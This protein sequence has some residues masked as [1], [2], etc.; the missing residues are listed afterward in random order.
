MPSSSRRSGRLVPNATVL[1]DAVTFGAAVDAAAAVDPRHGRGR[2][3]LAAALSGG[4][5]DDAL[6]ALLR[7]FAA[8]PSGVVVETSTGPT[9]PHSARS[10]CWQSDSPG[11][12]VSFSSPS[13]ETD[14]A[15]LLR[16]LLV[17]LTG[18]CIRR[19]T[20]QPLSAE[21]V[22]RLGAVSAAQAVEIHRVTRG[23]PVL[24][25]EV[26]AA[27]GSGVAHTVRDAV[28]ARLG[29]PSP[30]ARTLV[31]RLSVVPTRAERGLAE[32]LAEGDAGSSSRPSGSACSSAVTRRS[33]S[34]TN[35]PVR[36]SSPP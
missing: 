28:V 31:E 5:L 16:R 17:T 1:V 6:P 4:R 22:H 19:V 30:A 12:P 35:W 25:T 3:D 34:D 15:H 21:A 14:A 33:R 20:L 27:G 2:P 24:V 32:T 13:R 10:A 7:I 18:P 9:M 8:R 36:R 29:T 26:L 23:N 11:L